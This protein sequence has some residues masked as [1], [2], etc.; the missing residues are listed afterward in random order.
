ME[1]FSQWP[2]MRLLIM[3]RAWSLDAFENSARH[4]IS[5]SSRTYTHTSTP[6]PASM[7]MLLQKQQQ[8]SSL[9]A[10]QPAAARGLVVPRA[11]AHKPLPYAA[12]ALEPHM[13]KSTFE[14]RLPPAV[15]VR[16]RARVWCELAQTTP[17]RVGEQASSHPHRAA[18]STAAAGH[19]WAAASSC[20]PA[21]CELPPPTPFVPT[22]WRASSPLPPPRPQFH[23][24]KHHK[25]YADNLNK[26][27]AGKELDNKSVG[28]WACAGQGPVRTTNR[29]RS[30]P[31]LP[32]SLPAPR[33]WMRL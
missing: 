27:I 2:S 17:L 29:P 23:H 33:S 15:P 31:L 21:S 22:T 5:L 3:M 32:P 4:L 19:A 30:S 13:S 28:A 10:A 20:T 16:E 9:R 25:A 8:A 7:S 18:T 24:G 12:D 6:P 11:V 1:S 26:Q 14:V